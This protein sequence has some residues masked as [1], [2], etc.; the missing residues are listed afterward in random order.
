MSLFTGVSA[1]YNVVPFAKQLDDISLIGS[2]VNTL[3]DTGNGA[4]VN[5][6]F[7]P[8]LLRRGGGS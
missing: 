8:D 3:L 4:F 5:C 2:M 1:V 6:D 7:S